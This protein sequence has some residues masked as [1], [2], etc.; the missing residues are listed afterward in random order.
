V[1]KIE[2]PSWCVHIG[3]LSAYGKI[4]KEAASQNILPLSGFLLFLDF[5]PVPQP[6]NTDDPKEES[7]EKREAERNE[8][9]CVNPNHEKTLSVYG[10][11]WRIIIRWRAFR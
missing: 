4:S 5:C 8:N 1:R 3:Y 9:Y 10:C 6:H 11:G 7:E 2:N